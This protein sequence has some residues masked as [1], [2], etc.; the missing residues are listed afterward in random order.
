MSGLV[1][2]YGGSGFVGR[3]IARR[4]AREW[5]GYTFDPQSA[6]A[7]KVEVIGDYESSPVVG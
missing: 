2:I 7:G 1:T 5:L 3:Y 6:S 4:L